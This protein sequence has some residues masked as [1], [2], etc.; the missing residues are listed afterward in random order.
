[1][2]QEQALLAQARA[3]DEAGDAA[4]EEAALTRLLE[5][6]P[7]SVPGHV[8]KGHCRLRAGDHDLAIFFYRRG[9][10]LAEAAGLSPDSDAE[11]KEARRALDGLEAQ[12]DHR[13]RALL[14]QRGLPEAKWS[15][16]LREALD[17]A[18]GRKRQ[19]LQEPTAFTYPRLPHVQFFDST[20]FPWAAAVEAAAPQIKAELLGLLGSGGADDFKPYI[21]ADVSSIPLEGNSALKGS[22]DWSI[23]DLCER[24]WLNPPVIERCPRTWETVLSAPLPRIA[25]W[26]PTVVFSMLKAGAHIAP[27]TGMF[28][29]RLICHLP[30]IL[31]PNCRFRCG[32]EVREWQEGKLMIFDDTIE[33]EAWNESDSDRVVLIFDIWRPELSEQERWELTALF[34][35]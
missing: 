4:G 9:L 22:R 21:K 15:P 6:A 23:L 8:L 29:T 14:A 3:C 24:G 18:A 33:H 13:R 2:D 31:P 20:P 10:A 32:N 7:R 16:R 27:H 35:D 19:Y 11:V 34:S 12:V 1:M 17:V 28:N 26:G 25:G 5:R 30:L